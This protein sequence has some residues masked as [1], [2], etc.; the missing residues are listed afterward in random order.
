VRS[1]PLA[2]IV[3]DMGVDSDNFKAELLLKGLGAIERGAGTTAA[4]AAEVREALDEAGVPLSG[5]RV[6][7]GSGLSLLDRLTANALVAVLRVSW[8]DPE[9][10]GPV[11]GALPVAARTG[12]LAHRMR[13]TAAAGVVRAKTGTTRRACAL[14]GYVGSRYA[15]AVL[16]NGRPVP[17]A[18]ARAAQDRFAVLL[19]RS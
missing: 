7:D 12:T 1:A 17:T 16:Q 18:A 14:A 3:R 19:A 4:G 6:V 10:R 8:D 13:R 15:F 2:A 11:L 9:L 5:V